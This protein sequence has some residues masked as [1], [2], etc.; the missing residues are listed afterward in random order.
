[1][2][3]RLGHGIDV[4]PLKKN[5]PFILGGVKIDSKVG[6]SGHSDGDILIHA[7][8]DALLGSLALGD[9]GS[10]FPSNKK[11]ENCDSSVF[12]K[13]ALKKITSRNYYI[14]NIDSTIILQYPQINQ[15]IP[16]IQ[17][18]LAGILKLDT[19][20]ISIKATT[21]D[22]LGFIGKNKGIA[23]MATVLISKAEE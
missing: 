1:M 13:E 10:L 4:H 12:L 18:N 5:C 16:K 11:W 17:K 2:K 3:I 9:I 7:I 8:V 20:Q 14:T 6:I 19:N 15:Y 22:Y 21:T 23:T